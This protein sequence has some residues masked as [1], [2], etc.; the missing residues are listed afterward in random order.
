MKNTKTILTV[1][2]LLIIISFFAGFFWKDFFPKIQ[3]EKGIL[4]EKNSDSTVK[5]NT[6]KQII[7]EKKPLEMSE[8][9]SKKLN[10]KYILKGADYA[11]FEF[12]DNKTL[13]W[14]NEMFPMDPDTMRLKWISKDIFVGIFIEKH[15]ENCPPNVWVNKVVSYDGHKLI[16]KDIWTGW[17][18][19][20]DDLKTF[21]SAVE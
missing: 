1:S 10:G 8:N 20:K 21:Y 17:G 4:T 9:F 13:T 5:N 12:V 16:L 6:Q 11:G 15:N 18:D 3:T 19:S 7:D 2:I 14:T